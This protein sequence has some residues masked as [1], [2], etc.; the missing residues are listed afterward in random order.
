VLR[1]TA[2]KDRSIG[3]VPR[4]LVAALLAAVLL[5]P[6]NAAAKGPTVRGEIARLAQ[7]GAIVPE[8][9]TAWR[10]DYDNAQKTLKK[11][12]GTRLRELR[13]VVVNVNDAARRHQFTPSRL[14]AMFMTL[15]RNRDWWATKPLP[16]GGQRTS[17]SPSQLVWQYYP[18]QG[19]QIQWLATF[20]IANALWSYGGKDDE[21]RRLLDEALTYATRRAGGI[22]FEYLFTFDGGTPPWVSGLAQGTGLSALSRGAVR[23]KSPRYFDAAR[24]AL[25]IFKTPPPTGVRFTRSTGV[26]YLQ[27]S[28]AP[29]LRIANGFTQALNGLHDFAALANDQEGRTLF[30]SG[31]RELRHELPQFDTGAWSI[32]S[33]VGGDG[34][35]SD[36]GYHKVL[37]DFVQNLCDRLT[38]A[39][40]DPS[41]KL[42]CSTAARFTKDLTTPP[43]V[44]FKLPKKPRAKRTITVRFT[45]D[46]I[47][48]VTITATRKDKVVYSV[49]R[50]YAHGRHALKLTP[51][52]AGALT[53]RATSVDLAGNT[54]SDQAVLRVKAVPKKKKA[55]K[56]KSEKD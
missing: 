54:G 42:Y 8:Q 11:L 45:L 9:A 33:R 47:S 17:F 24:E 36:L 21:L 28:Y 7:K 14:P 53:L 2:A 35:E 19:W 25:G 46:K 41:P 10:A 30:A 22:A 4:T 1:G 34:I 29:K 12:H 50:R 32:Y 5:L 38:K 31:E 52:A 27:Y 23:L 55:P 40:D 16:H 6:A 3:W 13:A 18:G 39:G 26:H 43:K 15:R 48:T 56:K 49:T 44:T 37:R 20:G 51:S